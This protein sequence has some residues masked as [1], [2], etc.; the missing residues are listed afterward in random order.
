MSTET[1]TVIAGEHGPVPMEEN[2]RRFIDQEPVEVD[3]NSAYY[4]RRLMSG[5]LVELTPEKMETRRKQLTALQAQRA[6]AEAAEEARKA[7][8]AATASAPTGPPPTDKPPL[9]APPPAPAP[10]LGL[11]SRLLDLKGDR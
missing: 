10:P 6:A 2:T 9:E 8:E 3:A 5:E 11:I 4:A 1:K 7:S